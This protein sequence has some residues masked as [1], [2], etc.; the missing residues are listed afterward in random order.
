MSLFN[1]TIIIPI[2]IQSLYDFN[3]VKISFI[4]N[5][6]NDSLVSQLIDIKIALVKVS[7]LVT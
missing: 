4:L 2:L 7:R 3:V 1:I 5:Y 6:K